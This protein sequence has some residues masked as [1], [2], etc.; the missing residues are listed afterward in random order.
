MYKVIGIQHRKYTNKSG[1]EVEGYNLFLTYEDKAVNGLGALR[2]WVN[3]E[4]MEE[5][6]VNVGDDCELMYNRWGR[7]ERISVIS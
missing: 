7:I 3:P 1:K 6:M 4:T 2:E 5:S